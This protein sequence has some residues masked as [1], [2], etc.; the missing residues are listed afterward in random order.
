MSAPP[1][2]LACC[3]C[4]RRLPARRDVYVLDGEW[5]R[6]YPQMRGR[7]ACER[8][9]LRDHYWECDASGAYPPGHV[10]ATAGRPD[11]DSWCHMLAH[12]TLKG[13]TLGYPEWAVEQGGGEYVRWLVR[14]R[15]GGN[16]ADA[17]AALR[18][19][20]GEWKT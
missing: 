5:A 8:C 3:L 20:E 1:L 9:A 11:H 6:R 14:R 2:L 15:G 17:A 7:I 13:V 16:A 10:A 19:L 12:G 18:A 4:A